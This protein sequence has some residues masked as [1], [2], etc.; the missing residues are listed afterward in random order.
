PLYLRHKWIEF[1]SASGCLR[2]FLQFKELKR[3]EIEVLP[4]EDPV[5]T[6]LRSVPDDGPQGRGYNDGGTV[7]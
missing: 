5:A 7:K 2:L 1:I 3:L 4:F 6:L